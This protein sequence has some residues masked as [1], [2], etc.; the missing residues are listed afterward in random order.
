MYAVT[1]RPWIVA[2]V[3]ALAGC[4]SVKVLTVPAPL[5]LTVTTLCIARE[6][7]IPVA[8]A[9]DLRI[10]SNGRIYKDEDNSGTCPPNVATLKVDWDDDIVKNPTVNVSD[11]VWTPTK[12][13][14]TTGSASGGRYTPETVRMGGGST[15]TVTL[16][17]A[18]LDPGGH[19]VTS[20]AYRL[21]ADGSDSDA[22]REYRK[23]LVSRLAVDLFAKQD[24]LRPYAD[25]AR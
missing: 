11:Q 10:A 7:R 5:E 21:N 16:S 25:R 3:G 19:V 4:A 12:N 8:L 22:R 15:G 24:E 20:F 18:V 23:T 13:R 17:G 6:S 2:L 9:E 1:M 14:T